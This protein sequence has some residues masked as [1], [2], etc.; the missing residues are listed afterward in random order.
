MNIR[1]IVLPIVCATSQLAFA[2]TPDD[3]SE[4]RP[5]T[6]AAPAVRTDIRTACPAI[7]AQLQQSF[8]SAWGRV[9]I[10]ETI[11]VQFRVEGNRVTETLTPVT[12][13]DYRPYLRTAM[14]R[15]DCAVASGEA[16]DFRFLLVMVDP[17]DRSAS[18]PG[19]LA[20]ALQAD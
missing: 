1:H 7:D 13:I 18:A 14:S 15:L 11:P 20:V 3:S 12:A 9:H 16:Q 19:P 5:V 6:V 2:A 10:A 17:D 4:L 8:S